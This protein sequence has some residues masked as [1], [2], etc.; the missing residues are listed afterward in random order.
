MSLEYEYETLTF[1]ERNFVDDMHDDHIRSLAFRPYNKSNLYFTSLVNK[2]GKVL[3]RLDQDKIWAI[4]R[5]CQALIENGIV[6]ASIFP[7]KDGGK[8][9]DR[10]GHIGIVNYFATVVDDDYAKA[11]GFKDESSKN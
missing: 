5:Y 3:S 4:G 10:P 11:L 7:T 2:H 1:D 9:S 8:P 6:K